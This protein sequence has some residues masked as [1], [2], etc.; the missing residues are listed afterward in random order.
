[1]TEIQGAPSLKMLC[2][3]KQ[4]RRR[5]RAAAEAPP[6]ELVE[7]LEGLLPR[8]QL[9]RALEGLEPEEITGPGGLLSKLAGRVIET[10]LGAELEQHLG[11]PPGGLPAGENVR[12]GSTS[13]T[14]ATDLG[15][16]PI[17]TPATVTPASSR[18]WSA[19]ARPAGGPGR[20]DPCPLRGRDDGARHRP[21]FGRAV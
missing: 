8:E 6:D 16:V 14:L 19:S 12:N 7:R 17:R 5:Q 18:S 1:M 13:K 2:V 11:H 20:Q 3:P 4:R 9:E 21:P 10:A 15:P